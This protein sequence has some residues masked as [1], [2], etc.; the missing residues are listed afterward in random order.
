LGDYDIA[1]YFKE[2]LSIVKLATI[3]RDLRAEF[4]EC[5][6][7]TH[8]AAKIAENLP[9]SN[10]DDLGL[11]FPDLSVPDAPSDFRVKVEWLESRLKAS[12][13]DK[14]GQLAQNDLIPVLSEVISYARARPERAK[15][16]G[17]ASEALDALIEAFMQ[18]GGYRSL[19]SRDHDLALTNIATGAFIPL[20]ALR[21]FIE[22]L[23]QHA[24]AQ[25]SREFRQAK[26]AQNAEIGDHL[27]CL[28]IANND[29]GFESF[30]FSIF[31]VPYDVLL[32]P[33]Q[34]Q[35]TWQTLSHELSHILTAWYLT[36]DDF[37]VLIEKHIDAL[38]VP[39]KIPKETY[40]TTVDGDF[41]EFAAHYI[42]FV[43]FYEG[44]LRKY[45]R[46]IWATWPTFASQSKNQQAKNSKLRHYILRSF[47][48]YVA[49]D[50]DVI[51]HLANLDFSKP[52]VW[53]KGANELLNV[54]VSKFLNEMELSV[55]DPFD[56]KIVLDADS[57]MTVLP[58]L[59][60][61]LSPLMKEFLNRFSNSTIGVEAKNSQPV[62]Y[63]LEQIQAGY[64]C[65]SNKS[66]LHSLVRDSHLDVLS[67]Q[68]GDLSLD[69]QLAL[70]LTYARD[71]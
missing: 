33:C 31:L 49:Q 65:E 22:L 7:F 2:K 46:A 13:K 4:P 44:N 45:L 47:A 35:L 39:G 1:L 32:L 26:K 66:V 38:A 54:H 67:N 56:L 11:T 9:R 69:G 42:D 61:R 27:S 5:R 36:D 25:V 48:V 17:F 41:R 3:T 52:S 10:S 21:T 23:Y 37:Q 68:H 29:H 43:F 8:I 62:S 53:L 64:I 28:P 12:S 71:L 70:M 18:R 40:H 15:T 55:C 63:E 34:K 19:P 30:P 59:V 24:V 51:E 14:I 6:T 57:Q 58:M 16:S 50:R 20:K 60:G